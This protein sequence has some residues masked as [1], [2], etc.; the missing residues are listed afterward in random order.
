MCEKQ[1]RIHEL[2][3]ELVESHQREAD[4]F[5]TLA[6]AKNHES[7]IKWRPA[8]VIAVGVIIPLM[9]SM[10]ALVAAIAK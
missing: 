4:L 5:R 8:Q 9:V 2:E 1:D 7:Q 6:E 3:N 10:L